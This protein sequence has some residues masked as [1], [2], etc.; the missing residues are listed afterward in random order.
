MTDLALEISEA[1]GVSYQ[2]AEA[3]VALRRDLG[4]L[5]SRHREALLVLGEQMASANCRR[6]VASQTPQEAAYH[7]GAADVWGKLC[8]EFKRLSDELVAAE[9]HIQEEE[10]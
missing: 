3:Q 4:R 2:R 8:D 1:Q 9:A 10:N 5:V 6:M 7:I